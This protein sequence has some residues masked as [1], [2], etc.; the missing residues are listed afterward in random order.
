MKNMNLTDKDIK[1]CRYC[2]SPIVLDENLLMWVFINANKRHTTKNLNEQS[3]MSCLY[4]GRV[5]SHKP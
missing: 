3:D 2:K 5:Y 4:N 1:Y